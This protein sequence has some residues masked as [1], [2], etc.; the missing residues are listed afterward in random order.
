MSEI[1]ELRSLTAGRSPKRGLQRN[2]ATKFGPLSVAIFLFSM[3]IISSAQLGYEPGE[4]EA[5]RL[6][7]LGLGG[8][9]IISERHPEMY[10]PENKT[11]PPAPELSWYSDYFSIV[12]FGGREV[13][14]YYVTG[15]PVI[16]G[17]GPGGRPI[18]LP[19]PPAAAGLWILGPSSWTE[20]AIVP[21]GAYLRLIA[22]H[23]AGGAADLYEIT[24]SSRAVQRRY[25]L[26]PGYSL[27]A[28]HPEEVGRHILLFSA[29]GVTSNVVVVDVRQAAWPGPGPGPQPGYGSSQV[30]L[31]SANLRGYSVYVDGAYVGSD[32][33]VGD[34]KDGIFT[35]TVSGARSHT[36]TVYGS[37]RTCRCDYYYESGRSYEIDLCS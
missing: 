28:F 25:T 26:Y 3:I 17:A 29:D 5:E 15:T 13:E 6:F 32:G 37:G 34:A 22:L 35:I 33:Q 9:W 12:S 27:I 11:M 23:P 36:I 31:R 8:P 14:R 18:A 21:K 24:P 10:P 4:R 2:F 7:E 30:T 1:D 16:Y 19:Q 20:Y